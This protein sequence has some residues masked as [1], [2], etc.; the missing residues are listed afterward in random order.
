[1]GYALSR[2]TGL[3]WIA[4]FRDEW[5]HNPQGERQPRA[6]RAVSRAAERRIVAGAARVVVVDDAWEIEGLDRSS[7]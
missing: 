6:V 2:L 4:D 3:P 7:G 1:V 5:T